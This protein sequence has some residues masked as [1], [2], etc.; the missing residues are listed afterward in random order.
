MQLSDTQTKVIL[1]LVVVIVIGLGYFL[2][3]KSVPPEPVPGPGQTL[4]NP[5]GESP[6]ARRAQSAP[7]G[8]NASGTPMNVPAAGTV[9]PKRGFGPSKGAPIPGSR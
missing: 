3:T 5:L 7:S 8:T 9:D 2:W 4:K 6:G 1:V